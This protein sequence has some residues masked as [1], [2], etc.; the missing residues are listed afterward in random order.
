MSREMSR[1][2]RSPAVSRGDLRGTWRKRDPNAPT[3]TKEKFVETRQLD[4]KTKSN[5]LAKLA[6]ND[7]IKEH[8][9]SHKLHGFDVEKCRFINSESPRCDCTIALDVILPTFDN[10]NSD[11]TDNG[12]V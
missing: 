11:L 2:M 9:F 12:Q 5:F 6:L 7:G 8:I 3:E 10:P 4:V 1:R